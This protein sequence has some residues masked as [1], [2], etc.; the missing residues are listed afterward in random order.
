MHIKHGQCVIRNAKKVYS[1]LDSYVTGQQEIKRKII[2]DICQ[3][4]TMF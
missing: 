4:L 3:A 2:N 1:Y